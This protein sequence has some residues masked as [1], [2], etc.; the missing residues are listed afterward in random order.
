MEG[1]SLSRIS[2]GTRG[3]ENGDDNGD[4]LD[5]KLEP[6]HM[7]PT[8]SMRQMHHAAALRGNNQRLS[9]NL[10]KKYQKKIPE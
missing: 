8:Q 6:R 10:S 2:V 4:D 1:I 5:A 9:T 3:E 7:V